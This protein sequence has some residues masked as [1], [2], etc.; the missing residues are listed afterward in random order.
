MIPRYPYG[1]LWILWSN[2]GVVLLGISLGDHE[3]VPEPASARRVRDGEPA[4]LNNPLHYPVTAICLVCGQPIRT[5]R[6]LLSEW[7][8]VAPE[9]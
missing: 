3:I 4:D 5:E 7:R 8:H 6:W 9:P 1:T 2:D